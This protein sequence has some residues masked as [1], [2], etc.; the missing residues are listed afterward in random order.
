MLLKEKRQWLRS[1]LIAVSLNFIE[2]T[3]R[4][5]ILLTLVYNFQTKLTVQYYIR[6]F[7]ASDIREAENVWIINR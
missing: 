6:N 2:Q 5:Q 1:L 7:T 3:F 4:S